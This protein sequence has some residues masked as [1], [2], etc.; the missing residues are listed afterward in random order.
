MEISFG[1][2]WVS[3]WPLAI[4]VLAFL[5][6]R[7]RLR[8]F[9]SIYLFVFFL[10]SLYIIFVIDK[11]LFPILITDYDQGEFFH[12]CA[13]IN[14]IPFYFGR[15]IISRIIYYQVIANI[16]L[17]IPFGFGLSF[18]VK[19]RARA[20]LWLPFAVGFGI[21]FVQFMISLV[22]GYL[23]RVI[24]V[25]D[26]IMNAIGVLIGYAFFRI[27]SII[28]LSSLKRDNMKKVGIVKFITEIA[29]R[30]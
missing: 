6:I 28:I 8:K 10:F 25:N 24:D 30:A 2:K 21:E 9:N 12:P 19:V 29:K 4:V 1:D 16:L 7:L 5:L 18:V 27:F 26:V 23:Y 3:L 13:G 15:S 17:T 14:L 22:L 11:T 20:F